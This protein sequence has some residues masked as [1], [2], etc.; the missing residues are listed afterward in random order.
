MPM[1]ASMI[2]GPIPS[3]LATAIF[4]LVSFYSEKWFLYLYDSNASAKL[5]EFLLL[6][7]K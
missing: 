7:K 3:P 1:T 2:S 6:K 5:G 4:I